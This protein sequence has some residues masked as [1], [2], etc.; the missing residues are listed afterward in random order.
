MK[1][2]KS[3]IQTQLYLVPDYID[4]DELPD[5]EVALSSVNYLRITVKKEH[6]EEGEFADL[7]K[8]LTL[9][10]CIRNNPVFSICFS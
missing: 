1:S 2:F 10:V 8:Q 3:A 4:T 5:F 7:L 9:S 6:Q